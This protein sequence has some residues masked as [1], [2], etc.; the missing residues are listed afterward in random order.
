[1]RIAFVGAGEVSIGTAKALTQKNHE[2]II[3]ESSKEKIEE[4][5]QE[6]DCSFLQGDGSRPD[7]LR[8]VN[9][10]QTDV[11]FCLTNSDQ[12]NLI[13]SLIGRSLGFKRV[14]TSI[15]DAQFES[16]CMELGLKDTI[17]PSRTISRYLEDMVSGSENVELST[18]IKDEARFFSLIA[19]EEDAVSA[20]ELELPEDAKA[21]C[22]YRDGKFFHADAD[23]KFAKGDEIVILTHSKNIPALQERWQAKATTTEPVEI[24]VE[25][26][27]KQEQ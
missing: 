9:P 4:L 27:T 8:E 20:N 26:Q 13:A 24:S 15:A 7:I 18:V 11:L 19:R 16:I 25:Q 17:V 1:M 10:T 22:Y 2:V 6:M 21:I 3:I 5:S 23:T 12:I 14:V